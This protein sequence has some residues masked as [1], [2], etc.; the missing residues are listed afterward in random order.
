MDFRFP[1]GKAIASQLAATLENAQLLMRFSKNEHPPELKKITSSIIRGTGVME[2]IGLGRAYLIEGSNNNE[3]QL[4]AGDNRYIETMDAFRESISETEKQ[5]EKLQQRLEEELTD[6]A[7]LIFSAH[8]LMLRDNGFSGAMEQLI[9]DGTVPSK[10]IEQVTNNYISIFAASDNPRLREKI[11]DVKD[12]GHRLLKNLID[13]S[14]DHGDY[15]GQIVIT[16][17]LLPSEL[18]KLSAQNVEGIVL[19]GGGA[20][21]HVA[22][23]A[24]SLRVPLIYTEDESVFRIPENTQLAL[25]AF[26]AV[27]LVE[28]DEKAQ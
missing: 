13:G 18:L 12:L 3:N 4:I 2:G 14:H 5:L 7:S 28:P 21:A 22:V 8:L 6:V 15:S 16:N 1:P 11:L 10:A 25:D 23:L 9:H 26:Q 24:R 17:E 27:L 19:F 20:T